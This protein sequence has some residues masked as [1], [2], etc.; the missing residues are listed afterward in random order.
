MTIKQ[1]EEESKRELEDPVEKKQKKSSSSSRVDKEKEKGAVGK[2][3]FF[4]CEIE[5]RELFFSSLSAL[6]FSFLQ[7]RERA[8]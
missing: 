1:D 2:A 6:L 7:E 5:D 4:L 3:F 8:S